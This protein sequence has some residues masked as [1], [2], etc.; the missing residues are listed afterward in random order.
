MTDHDIPR[1]RYGRPIIAVPHAS[2]G[3]D[4]RNVPY[5]RTSTL[6]SALEDQTGLTKW[7][8]RKV[9]QGLAKSPALYGKVAA[10]EGPEWGLDVFLEEAQQIAGS[11]EKAEYGTLIHSLC[12]QLDRGEGIE[13]EDSSPEEADLNAYVDA[14][15]NHLLVL[16]EKFTVCDELQVAGTPDAVRRHPETTRHHIYDIKTGTVAYKGKVKPSIEIQLAVYA[17][18]VLY[19]WTTETRTP[20]PVDVDTDWGFVIHLP[21]GQGK[22]EIIPV[23]LQKGWAGAQLAAEVL[24]HR[25]AKPRSYAA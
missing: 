2:E 5:T 20:Y 21:A 17:R 8:L 3:G 4:T 18:S 13:I 15:E 1:D 22:A 24:A 12:E 19:D 23:D 7:Q 6:G 10:H 25:K 14:T 9:A 11:K 16:A